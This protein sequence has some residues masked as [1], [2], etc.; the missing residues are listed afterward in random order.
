MIETSKRVNMIDSLINYLLETKNK[1]REIIIKKLTELKEQL[2]FVIAWA[3]YRFAI[4]M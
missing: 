2:E 4:Y 1:D 3:V